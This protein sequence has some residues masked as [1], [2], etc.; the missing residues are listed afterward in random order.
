MHAEKTEVGSVCVMTEETEVVGEAALRD[1]LLYVISARD[2][3]EMSEES[4][5]FLTHVNDRMRETWASDETALQEHDNGSIARL[6][7]LAQSE[8]AEDFPLLH[9]HSLVGLW[10]ALE[11]CISDVCVEWVDHLDPGDWS[12]EMAGLKVHLG[13]WS[14]LPDTDRAPWLVDQ[15]RKNRSSDLNRGIGQ[16]ESVLSAIGL[17]GHVDKSISDVM[18]QTKAIRNVIAHRGGRVDARFVRECPSFNMVVG[19]KLKLSGSQLVAAYTAM[20]MYVESILDR[21]LISKGKDPKGPENLPPWVSS[22][23]ELRTLIMPGTSLRDWKKN[24]PASKFP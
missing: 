24:S 9:S 12:K 11:A 15:I 1:F 18:S 6:N 4:A 10:G 17:G 16:F 3:I 8:I 14:A 13:E 7:R 20:V 19:E 2:L 21:V 23:E 5:H 22:P